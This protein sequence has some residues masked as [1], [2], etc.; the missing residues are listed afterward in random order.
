MISGKFVRDFKH[1][2]KDELY[3]LSD[4]PAEN[5]N[6]I[7]S[8]DPAVRKK[9]KWL[10]QKLFENMKRINDPVLKLKK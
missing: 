5:K 2:D 9:I 6:L 4:D 10:N 7:N 1:Q 3:N 8:P